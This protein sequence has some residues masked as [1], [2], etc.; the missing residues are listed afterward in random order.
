[1]IVGAAAPG[2]NWG[3]LTNQLVGFYEFV[4]LAASLNASVAHGTVRWLGHPLAFPKATFPHGALWDVG[5]WNAVSS[6]AGSGLPLM[7]DAG[8]ADVDEWLTVSFVDPPDAKLFLHNKREW[9][10]APLERARRFYEALKP[11]P[12][13]KVSAH[14]RARST[15]V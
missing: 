15:K 9:G 14:C 6:R 4:A 7:V 3:G 12:F 1:M 2:F 11:A 5:H 10:G 13:A 8:D